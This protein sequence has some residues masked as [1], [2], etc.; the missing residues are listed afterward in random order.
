MS[1][2]VIHLLNCFLGAELLDLKVSHLLDVVGELLVGLV[3]SMVDGATV[4]VYHTS[5]AVDVID[6]C[7]CS[8]FST[9]TVATNGCEGDLVFIHEPHYIVRHVLNR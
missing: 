8:D 7:D 4:E 3:V 5:E 6:G 2:T 1:N 9:E